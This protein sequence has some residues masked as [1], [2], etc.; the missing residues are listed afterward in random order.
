MT[1]LLWVGGVAVAA[2][3]GH[4]LSC[5]VWPFRKCTA[6]RG[7]KIYD[8][9]TGRAYR[10]CTKCVGKGEQRRRPLRLGRR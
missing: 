6:C 9:P 7:R 2:V 5:R 3:V 4:D 1:E 10:K 8:S